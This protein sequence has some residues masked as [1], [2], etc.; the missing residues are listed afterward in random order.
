MSDF[1]ID[2][3]Y[4]EMKQINLDVYEMLDTNNEIRTLVNWH[5]LF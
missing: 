5:K 4:S 1:I 3:F 2:E